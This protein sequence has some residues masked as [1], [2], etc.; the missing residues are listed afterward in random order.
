MPR[1]PKRASEVWN[2][3]L[4]N[5]LNLKELRA[6]AEG[7]VFDRFRK[8]AILRFGTIIPLDELAAFSGEDKE[9]MIGFGWDVSTLERALRRGR[10]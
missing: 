6:T 7:E 3:W 10:F 8:K 1:R 5:W 2:G 9:T 4:V